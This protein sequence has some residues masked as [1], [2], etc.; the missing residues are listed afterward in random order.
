MPTRP[1]D[2]IKP[3]GHPDARL[4]H[5]LERFARAIDEVVNFGTHVLAA[6]A[7][8]P[9]E[10]AAVIA[11]FRHGLELLD[12][13]AA[14]VRC[15]LPDP[16]KP[17]L[18]ACLEASMSARFILKEKTVERNRSF[19]AEDDRRRLKMLKRMDPA[20]PEGRE[21]AAMLKKDRLV[22]SMEQKP[23][24][25]LAAGVAQLESL[26][27]PTGEFAD[28]EAERKTFAKTPKWHQLFGG[29]ATIQGIAQDLE[30]PA[31][32]EFVYRDWSGATHGTDV[33]SGRFTM[34]KTGPALVQLRLPD[35]AQQVTSFAISIGLEL[36]QT[37][38]EL[39]VPTEKDRYRDWH[40]QELR[41]LVQTITFGEQRIVRQ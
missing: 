20:T 39:L 5:E 40:L 15:S 37:F 18:R 19:L 10:V 17:L 22:G 2:A 3:E 35:D 24:P 31:V 33:M 26:F 9:R 13:V 36:I 16:A 34:E 27:A 25:G 12:A 7:Q 11:L 23:P 21:F 28:V 38:V 4:M 1:V 30:M 41:P 8:V 32:Y 29:P 14:L 6:A